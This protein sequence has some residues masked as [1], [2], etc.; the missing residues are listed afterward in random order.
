MKRT[1]K[2]RES[3]C[4]GQIRAS[5]VDLKSVSKSSVTS[6]LL[7]HSTGSLMKQAAKNVIIPNA[8]T[9][10]RLEWSAASK[11]KSKKSKTNSILV[12]QS[13]NEDT[14][15]GG[16]VWDLGWCLS[17]LLISLS[18]LIESLSIQPAS[19]AVSNTT[20]INAVTPINTVT[21]LSDSA[22]TEHQQ[23]CLKHTMT[24]PN[25]YEIAFMK[26]PIFLLQHH[27][28]VDQ[29]DLLNHGIPRKHQQLPSKNHHRI[30]LELGCGVGLT[31]LV[32]SAAF[33]DTTVILTDLP[34]VIDQITIPNVQRNA[35]TTIKTTINVHLTAKDQGNHSV[36]SM[37]A[38][39]N[40]DTQPS[41]H[42]PMHIYTI[43]QQQGSRAVAMP[44]SWG[45][46]H[47][48]QVVQEVIRNLIRNN[49]NNDDTINCCTTDQ[50]KP[51]WIIIADVAYQHK[52]GALSHFDAL[53]H[54]ILHFASNETLIIFGLRVRMSASID[55]Y[56]ML[57]EH[58]GE[59]VSDPITAQE[60]DPIRFQH[61]KPNTMSMHFMKRKNISQ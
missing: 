2:K 21:I 11:N 6:P 54:T 10:I 60:I 30:V 43:S 56:N 8:I 32:C 36:D 58:F 16:A 7:L 41:I 5:T 25:R 61:V 35:K 33:H 24:L 27:Q 55:L 4:V 46:H 59:I 29:Y 39:P 38:V 23:Q 42:V 52:P 48:E 34:M 18:S 31:G 12:Y 19:I 49:V 40:Q 22:S 47:D 9:P 28:R 45:N 26:E 51:D 37:D 14:W 17:Q 44:L 13:S 1:K 3:H 15:P 57:L 20:T 50:Y 53:L